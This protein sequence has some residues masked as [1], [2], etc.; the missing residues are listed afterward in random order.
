MSDLKEFEPEADAFIKQLEDKEVN[1]GVVYVIIL[2][3]F[4]R[5][6][7]ADFNDAS[8]LLTIMTFWLAKHKPDL[9]ADDSDEDDFNAEDDDFDDENDEDEE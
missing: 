2:K 1:Y 7:N 6:A 9:I 4:E 5:V 8:Q 3:L